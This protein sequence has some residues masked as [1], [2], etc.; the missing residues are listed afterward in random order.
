M[1]KL[2]KHRF[3]VASII[4]FLLL[5]YPVLNAQEKTSLEQAIESALKNHPSLKSSEISIQIADKQLAAEKSNRLPEIS[6]GLSVQRNL[7]IPSTPVPLAAFTGTGNPNDLS[8]LKFGTDWQ[9]NIGLTLNYDIF[10][11]SRKQKIINGEENQLLAEIDYKAKEANVKIEVS[12]AYA[13]LVLA[14]QQLSFAID[15]T[16]LNFNELTVAKDLFGKGRLTDTQLNDAELQLNQSVNRM[17]QAASVYKKAQIEL[18]Y[19][20]GLPYTKTDL[21]VAEDDLKNLLSKFNESN[22]I[23]FS[24]E[25]SLGYNKLISQIKYDSLQ[26]KNTRLLMLPTLS[27]FANY[28]SNYYHSEFNPF[29]T[30]NWYGNS[31]VGVSVNIPISK[32]IATHYKVSVSRLQLEQGTL[33]LQDF[34]NRKNADIQKSL[35]DIKMNKENLSNSLKEMQIAK[36][37]MD[38]SSALFSAGKILPGELQQAQLTYQSKKVDYLQK[39]YNLIISNLNLQELMQSK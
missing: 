36:E 31:F 13:E 37:N 27:F 39:A 29:N 25:N 12:R 9:S 2:N 26:I 32:D 15:D 7:I 19:Q 8:Y 34:N 14:S 3:I 11:P 33:E 5:L 22:I 20:M 38:H 1:R 18:G 4:I 28:G 21:P 10:D 23:S 16:L 35:F 30:S 17:K 6:S 24:P